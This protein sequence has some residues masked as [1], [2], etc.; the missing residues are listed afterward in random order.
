[1]IAE[2]IKA[3]RLK[4]GLSQEELAKMAN[5]SR[6]VIAKAET[7]WTTPQLDNLIKIAD[8]LEVSLDALAERS[9]E[10][11]LRKNSNN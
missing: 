11:F 9:T 1:M 6:S 3:E 5:L 4:R 8:A 7:N 10:K 2:N